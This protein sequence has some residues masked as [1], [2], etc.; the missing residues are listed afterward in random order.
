VQTILKIP[1][2]K[3]D[4]I[5]HLLSGLGAGFFAVCIGSPV[6]VVCSASRLF[7]FIYFK[8]TC[9]LLGFSGGYYFPL[10]DFAF[11]FFR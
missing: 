8:L 2:F 4:V 6:D 5:T 9:Q 11:S 7:I 1:G 3:D 10:V